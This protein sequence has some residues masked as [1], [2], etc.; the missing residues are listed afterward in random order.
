[1]TE[2]KYAFFKERLKKI[3]KTQ[4]DLARHL[5]IDLPRIY[6]MTAGKREV[7][8]DE[9]FKI[10]DFLGLEKE[11]FVNYVANEKDK[12][13]YL[14]SSQRKKSEEQEREILQKVIE[15]SER[16]L[17]ERNIG[18]SPDKKAKLFIILRDRIRNTAS[19]DMEAEIIKISDILLEAL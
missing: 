9:I 19:E 4:A 8:P 7:Q 6:E 17:K 18:L 13:V 2:A 14:D 11:S 12:I 3:G 15:V 1:M 16:F 10:A 5:G